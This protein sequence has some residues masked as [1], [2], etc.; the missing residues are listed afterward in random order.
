MTTTKTI[1]YSQTSRKIVTSFD[2]AYPAWTFGPHSQVR[3]GLGCI[4]TSIFQTQNREKQKSEVENQKPKSDLESKY[5]KII[6]KSSAQ[7]FFIS[8]WF[9]NRFLSRPTHRAWRPPC[10]RPPHQCQRPCRWRLWAPFEVFGCGWFLSEKL[11]HLGTIWLIIGQVTEHF[12]IGS[13]S[14]RLW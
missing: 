13:W 4:L 8:V 3:A 14:Y 9:S 1:H 7:F 2:H 10:H 12:M 11:E 5:I 6:S